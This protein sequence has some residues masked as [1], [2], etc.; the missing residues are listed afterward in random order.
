YQVKNGNDPNSGNITEETESELE[1]F[2][3]YAKIVMG[4]LGHKVFEPINAQSL[5]FERDE[6]I[7]HIEYKKGETTG[8]RTN[9]GF[10]ILKGSKISPTITKSCPE[11]VLK[12]RDKYAD[13]INTS[14]ELTSDVLL[15]SPSAAAGF[16]GGASLNGNALWHDA[17][18]RSLKQIEG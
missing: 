13:K 18:G 14:Y 7:L 10:V 6:P 12:M 4:A 9:D 17:D 8:K 5:D 3:D 1:E 16:I 15:N 2:I 11:Y